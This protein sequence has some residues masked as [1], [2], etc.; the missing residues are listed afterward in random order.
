VLTEIYV[1]NTDKRQLKNYK[2][3]M[4]RLFS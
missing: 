1:V 3:D 4:F 2:S